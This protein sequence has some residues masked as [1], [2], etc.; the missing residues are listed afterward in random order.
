M[1]AAA[2]VFEASGRERKEERHGGVTGDGDQ[3]VDD[4]NSGSS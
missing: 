3:A 1:S 2:Q 4:G